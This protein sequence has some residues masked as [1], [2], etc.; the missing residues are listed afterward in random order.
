MPKE[1]GPFI[2]TLS[3][4]SHDPNGQDRWLGKNIEVFILPPPSSSK[5]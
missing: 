4:L 2:F 3:W 5:S 1:S